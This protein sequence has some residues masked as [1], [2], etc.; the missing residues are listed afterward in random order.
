MSPRAAVERQGARVTR[1]RKAAE[2][3]NRTAPRGDADLHPARAAAGRHRDRLRRRQQ[4]LRRPAALRKPEL[5]D[6]AGR[7]RRRHRAE[8]RR[9]DHDAAADHRPGAADE[10]VRPDRPDRGARLRGS[11]PRHAERRQDRLGGDLG[12]R[13][14]DHAGPAQGEQPGL[15]LGVQLPWFRPA[16]ARRRSFGRR[17]QPGAPG[18][19][20]AAGART[21]SCSTSRPTT[22]T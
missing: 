9:Q 16:E 14:D 15:R 4:G 3:G 10:R 21:C 8:R 12:R 5:P 7:N 18:Q 22:S 13:R 17:A 1:L 2:P 6:A 19:G 20:A 11:E